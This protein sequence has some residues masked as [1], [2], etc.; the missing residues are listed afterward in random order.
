M[1]PPVAKVRAELTGLGATGRPEHRS[2]DDIGGNRQ[3]LATTQVFEADGRPV[4]VVSSGHHRA[5]PVNLAGVLGVTT[6]RAVPDPVATLW[7]GQEPTAI[8]PVGHAEPLSVIIDVDLA[9]FRR[10]WVPAG[11]PGYLFPTT[12]AELLRITAGTAAEVGELPE[13][14]TTP[15]I[16]Q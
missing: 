1:P 4:L 11:A 9:Q 10:I 6:V 16:A 14:G 13:T 8:A 2:G 7:T 12:Y 5:D 15:T 3:T